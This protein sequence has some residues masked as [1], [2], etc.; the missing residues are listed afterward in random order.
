M[1]YINL[2][3]N[4]THKYY[5]VQNNILYK[6]TNID[7]NDEC[8]KYISFDDDSSMPENG[9]MPEFI[10]V[11]VRLIGASGKS[12]RIPF[13]FLESMI[14][15]GDIYDS[16]SN[17]FRP[18]PI[19]NKLKYSDKTNDITY[20][21]VLKDFYI[22]QCITDLLNGVSLSTIYNNLPEYC[23]ETGDDPNGYHYTIHLNDYNPHSRVPGLE[24]GLTYD[25]DEIK[26]SEDFKSNIITALKN[27][28]AKMINDDLEKIPELN[29]MAEASTSDD[30]III[31]DKD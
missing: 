1:E 27:K 30:A 20:S 3:T 6:I 19:H 14:Q 8:N 21:D 22:D 15:P 23:K 9:F 11:D 28:Y 29:K 25:N 12:Q 24:I 26:M 10:K 16:N 17:Q 7:D 13:Y 5:Y 18:N 31:K 4:A 2:N